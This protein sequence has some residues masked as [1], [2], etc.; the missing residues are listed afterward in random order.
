M[1]KLEVGTKV[2]HKIYG[3]CVIVKR[4]NK[5]LKTYR[6]AFDGT[7]EIDTLPENLT[8]V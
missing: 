3:E 4:P 8:V 2:K 7:Y 1:N 6:V 5:L